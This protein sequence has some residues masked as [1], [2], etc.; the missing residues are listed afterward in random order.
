MFDHNQNIL[1]VSNLVDQKN[2]NSTNTMGNACEWNVGML[3][4]AHI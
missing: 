4:D 3:N 1:I 2:P